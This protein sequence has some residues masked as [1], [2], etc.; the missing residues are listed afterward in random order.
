[1]KPRI[2]YIVCAAILALSAAFS[3]QA[4]GAECLVKTNA[5]SGAGSLRAAIATANNGGCSASG[6]NY[7]TRY[8]TFVS[9]PPSIQLIHIPKS[10]DIRLSSALP[11]LHSSSTTLLIT[12]D[13]SATVRLI[14]KPL[15]VGAHVI[16]DHVVIQDVDGVALDIHGNDSLI[17]NSTIAASGRIDTPAIRITGN[18]VSIANSTVANNRGIGIVIDD[19]LTASTCT[20]I[21]SGQR[22]HLEKNKVYDNGG[23]GVRIHAPYAQLKANEIYRNQGPG[24]RMAGEAGPITCPVNN[25]GLYTSL[26]RENSL[27]QNTEGVLVTPMPLAPPV[28][29]VDISH[30]T[31]QQYRIVGSIGLDTRTNYPWTNDH[32]NMQGAV[33]E[34]FLAEAGSIHQGSAFIARTSVTDP[35][36]R[37]FVISVPKPLIVNGHEVT[38]PIFVAT[39]TDPEHGNTSPYSD[40]LDV[41]ATTDWDKDGVPNEVEDENQ[42]GQVNIESGETDPRLPDTDGDGLTDGEERLHLGRLASES[43][44]NTDKDNDKRNFK[45]KSRLKAGNSDSD[46]DCL[47]DGLEMG[48]AAFEYPK[49]S[50]STYSILQAPHPMISGACLNLLKLHQLYKLDLSTPAASQLLITNLLFRNIN[51]PATIDNVIGIYDSDPSN[52]NTDPTNADT[53]GDGLF[54]GAEDWN[55]DG[56]VTTDKDGIALETDPNNS[57]SDADG[58]LDGDEDKNNNGVVDKDEASPLLSD[59]DHD[60]VTDHQEVRNGENPTNCDSDGDGLPDGIEDNQTVTIPSSG[61]LGAPVGGVNY[62]YP[63][64]MNSHSRDSDGDGLPD[65]EEDANHNG[66][67]DPMESDPSTPDTDNDGIDDYVESTGDTD[68]DGIPDF[69]LGDIS[70]GSKCSPAKTVL[71]LDCD[72]LSN[73]QDT[74]SDNDGCS[75]RAEGLGTQGS[76]SIPSAYTNASKA[77]SASGGG[78]AGGSSSGGSSAGGSIGTSTGTASPSI[79]DVDP[80]TGLGSWNSHWAG[81]TDGGGDCSLIRQTQIPGN[82]SKTLFFLAALLVSVLGTA[83][84]NLRPKS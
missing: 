46:G 73:A 17:I 67:L 36:H 32:F 70:N 15:S 47:P 41:A 35:I 84:T 82:S 68:H 23:A 34:L 83:R 76:Q 51:A 9:V 57:D 22:A 38:S 28:D 43:Y 11:E 60:G 44:I 7:Q 59:S 33:V 29:L 71:D 62:K 74:D 63:S 4:K 53:D 27:H 21:A 39:V 6:N 8:E 61:C 26:L 64:V 79:S 72:G 75:D 48:V 49:V 37:Q 2:I 66:W 1:M 14:G 42:D 19:A 45:D 18:R 58:L 80:R 50:H 3:M 10:A 65:G 77:C 81:R 52:K 69:Y 16:L 24:I 30:T 25:T 40:A 20:A 13:S 5:D 54:D 78:S 31:A 56:T 55:W 12:A